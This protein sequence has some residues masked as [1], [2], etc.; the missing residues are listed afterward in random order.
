MADDEYG[1]PI[2]FYDVLADHFVSTPQDGK[3]ILDLISQ[4]WTHSFASNFFSLLFHKWVRLFV[5]LLVS[6]ISMAYVY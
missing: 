4:W 6:F 3:P 1:G 5:S 2:C